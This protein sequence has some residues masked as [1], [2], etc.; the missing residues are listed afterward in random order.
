MDQIKTERRVNSFSSKE[1]LQP[2]RP[3]VGDI[4]VRRPALLI[5]QLPAGPFAAP[6]QQAVVRPVGRER[7]PGQLVGGRFADYDRFTKAWL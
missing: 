7:R 3:A 1:V 2:A 6:N 5:L 4:G